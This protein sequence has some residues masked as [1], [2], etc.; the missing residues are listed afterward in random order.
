MTEYKKKKQVIGIVQWFDVNK[1]IGFVKTEEGNFVKILYKFLPIKDGDFV[2]VK[3]NDKIKF[4]II[5]DINGP[6]AKNIEILK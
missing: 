5:D 4:E 3:E 6:I 1:G 2:L